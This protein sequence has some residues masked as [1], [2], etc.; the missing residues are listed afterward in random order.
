[1]ERT[2]T[3]TGATK[4]RL[5]RLLVWG[6]AIVAAAAVAVALPATARPAFPGQNG[7]IA[8]AALDGSIQLINADG[9]NPQTLIASGGDP[10]WSSDG[11]KIAYAALNIY[12]ADA[13]GS[14]VH[15][16]TN[17]NYSHFRPTWSPDGQ[18]IAYE[19][20]GTGQYELYVMNA[21][22]TNQTQLTSIGGSAFPA[23]S[24]NSQKIAF[25]DGNDIY[26][27]NADGSNLTQLTHS[28]TDGYR[29]NYPNW[30][31]DG[32]HIVFSSFRDYVDTHYQINVM[33]ADGTNS[34]RLTNDTV[35]DTEPAWSPDGTK[36]A[37]N[38]GSQICVMNADGS[39]RA[40]L[41]TT[42]GSKPDWQPLAQPARTATV[43]QPINTDGSSVFKAGKGVLPVKF[44]LAVGGQPTCTLPPATIALTQLSGAVTGPVNESDYTMAADSGSDFRIS[45]CQYIYNLSLTSLPAGTYQAAIN[46]D[47]TTVG[48]ATF[49]L[50]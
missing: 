27:I 40:R 3:R 35:D 20:I 7:K 44:T 15:Q 24:P 37:F 36:I 10:A 12:V 39:N 38:C 19:S 13:N 21:D 46:I 31:P 11:Q 1:M 47:N 26:T 9:S 29:H 45:S 50:R 6:P 41:T 25:S 17:E 49:E 5:R 16:L 8:Y 28:S 34:T 2:T 32:T 30:S 33:N 4:S 23:W 43:Q 48:N 22:G 18:K 14:N 42:G